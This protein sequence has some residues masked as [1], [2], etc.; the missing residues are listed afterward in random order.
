MRDDLVAQ[1]RSIRAGFGRG[2]PLVF[3][4]IVID[5]RSYPRIVSARLLQPSEASELDTAEEDFE[6]RVERP[7]WR[8][9]RG[10]FQRPRYVG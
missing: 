7:P 6:G 3:T 8:Q 1:L 10:D 4:L 2:A 5:G 9:A